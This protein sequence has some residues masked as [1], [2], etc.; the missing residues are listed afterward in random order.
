MQ[1]NADDL[2][3]TKV[4]TECIIDLLMSNKIHSASILTNMPYT[5]YAIELIKKYNLKNKINL[6][7]NITQGKALSGINSLTDN[8]GYLSINNKYKIN[9]LNFNDIILE[10][11]LQS[12]IYPDFIGI[13]CHNNVNYKSEKL[14]NFLL[15]KHKNVRQ[16]DM[17]EELIFDISK[18][19]HNKNI[20]CHPTYKYD[21]EIN[22]CSKYNKERY[23]DYLIISKGVI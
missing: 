3:L 6:H 17:W 14:N 8:N 22:Q 1:I 20:Y 21:L 13:D 23:I 7:F 15:S 9:Q 12:K 18:N 5:E 4:S 16:R 2:G 19:R 11:E 10:F